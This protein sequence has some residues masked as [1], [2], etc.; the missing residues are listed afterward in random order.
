MKGRTRP[1]PPLA[2]A[3]GL[4]LMD[5]VPVT[6]RNTLDGIRIAVTGIAVLAGGA[7]AGLCLAELVRVF[8][9]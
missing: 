9:P 2:A 3:R 5:G 1:D 6:G 7:I 4:R 8:S